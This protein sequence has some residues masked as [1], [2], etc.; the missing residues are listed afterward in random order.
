MSGVIK[1]Y[2]EQVKKSNTAF[3]AFREMHGSSIRKV[4]FAI[5]MTLYL[6][7]NFVPPN[8]SLF[9][10]LLI[11]YSLIL[12]ISSIWI[13]FRNFSKERESVSIVG[14]LLVLA[15]SLVAWFLILYFWD[16]LTPMFGLLGI[17]PI[18]KFVSEKLEFVLKKL[19]LV[20][21]VVMV[22][23]LRIA[24]NSIY[25]IGLSIYPEAIDS[26]TV[27]TYDGML[28]YVFLLTVGMNLL[29]YLLTFFRRSESIKKLRSH[30]PIIM[31]GVYL[32][33]TAMIFSYLGSLIPGSDSAQTLNVVKIVT[34][35]LGVIWLI[36]G[37]VEQVLIDVAGHRGIQLKIRKVLKV[38]AYPN[39]LI[40]FSSTLMGIY[41]SS[42]PYTT[43]TGN[44]IALIYA[45]ILSP[46]S[47]LIFLFSYRKEITKKGDG[48]K[49]AIFC[50]NCGGKRNSGNL[51]CASCGTK[52]KT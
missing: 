40:L 9:L 15:V 11:N 2:K 39:L 19:H 41:I 50:S 1:V 8:A 16:F 27:S 42:S 14:I 22:I 52:F 47:F 34:V 32:Y 35:T 12:V 49:E 23:L 21:M 24:L 33:N 17:V 30:L 46:L 44:D 13:Y 4:L 3:K 20:I 38:N 6:A 45:S 28:V 48:Q 26:I 37:A 10:D 29:I 5:W 51:F 7:S 43:Y 18:V 36:K 25:F 31:V